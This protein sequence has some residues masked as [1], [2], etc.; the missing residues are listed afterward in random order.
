MGAAERSD[1]ASS[2]QPLRSWGSHAELGPLQRAIAEP[3]N[4]GSRAWLESNRKRVKGSPMFVV[5]CR[6]PNKANPHR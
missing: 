3:V 4:Q 1:S 6:V 2:V 5:R